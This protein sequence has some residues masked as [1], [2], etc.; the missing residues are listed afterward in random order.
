M[1]R[2]RHGSEHSANQNKLPSRDEASKSFGSLSLEQNQRIKHDFD[3]GNQKCFSTGRIEQP[4]HSTES[5]GSKT[6]HW[7]ELAVRRIADVGSASTAQRTRPHWAVSSRMPNHESR[8]RGKVLHDAD[9][10]A[11]N[12]PGTIEE[13]N[14]L[15]LPG[16]ASSW[17]ERYQD[18][19]FSEITLG[20]DSAHHRKLSNPEPG[21]QAVSHSSY[22]PDKFRLYRLAPQ[23][24]CSYP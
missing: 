11:R 3:R 20:K 1:I 5:V 14:S 23:P 9:R 18:L 21:T 8:T 22:L 2:F 17:E 16:E 24:Y 15:P 4:Y 7:D 13:K 19:A 6:K 10:T 12:G